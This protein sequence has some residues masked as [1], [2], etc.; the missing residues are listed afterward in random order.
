MHNDVD[1]EN[2]DVPW[3]RRMFEGNSLY[4]A[5]VKSLQTGKKSFYLTIG[6]GDY[7]AA[8]YSQKW[9]NLDGRQYS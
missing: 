6:L 2:K 5:V 1:Y 8:Y 4:L 3:H 7:K 9:V